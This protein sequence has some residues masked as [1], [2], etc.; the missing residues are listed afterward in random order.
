MSDGADRRFSGSGIP[1]DLDF[2]PRFATGATLDL[3]KSPPHLEGKKSITGSETW[4]SAPRKEAT[5]QKY[6]SVQSQH[7]NSLRAKDLHAANLNGK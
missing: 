2:L 1:D 6:A 4:V 7:S 3:R 5:K